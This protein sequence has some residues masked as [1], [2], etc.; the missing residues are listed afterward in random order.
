MPQTI[1]SLFLSDVTTQATSNIRERIKLRVEETCQVICK[2]IRLS[3]TRS[4][5]IMTL[6][7]R[8]CSSA[9]KTG[10]GVVVSLFYVAKQIQSITDIGLIMTSDEAQA[11]LCDDVSMKGA[12]FTVM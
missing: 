3:R 12:R 9:S 4:F 8:I 1:L 5:C 2:T 6:N 7:Q 10:V 11:P